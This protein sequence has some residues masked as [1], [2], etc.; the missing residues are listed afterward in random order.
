M[1][2]KG[3]EAFLK[4]HAGALLNSFSEVYFINSR[5]VGLAFLLLTLAN[6]RLALAGLITLAA[7]YGFA[8]LVGLREEFLQSGY[9]TYNPLLVGL[10]LGS[11]YG[12]S[13]LSLLLL[14]L[15]GVMTLVVTLAMAR[16]FYWYLGLPI[17][18][19]PFV[20][21]ISAM[22]LASGHYSNLFVASFYP[23]PHLPELPLPLWALGYFRSLAAIL[24]LPHSLLGLGLAVILLLASPLLFG[25]SVAGYYTGSLVSAAMTGSWEGAFLNLNHFNYILIA[26]GI[27]GVFLV[28]SPRSFLIAM[29]AVA[30]SVV[31][32][33]A[34]MVFW[35]TYGLPVLT[36]PFNL[37][38][39]GFV[40]ILRLL[41]N[42]L[43]ARR[44]MSAPEAT[45]DYH[46]SVTSRFDDC[47]IALALPFAGSW[48][49]WQGFS[50]PW[51][52]QGPWARAYDFILTDGEGQS[53]RGE[54]A[55]TKDYLAWGKPVLSPLSGRVVRVVKHHADQKI[56]Q[57]D[58]QNSWGNLVIIQTEDGWHV[59]LSHFQKDSLRVAE[60][61]WVERGS[62]LGLCGNSGNSP[63]PHIH[64]QVQIGSRIGESTL[65][66]RFS[67][68]LG[69]AGY[70]TKGLPEPGTWAESLP[71]APP[72]VASFPLTEKLVF[73]AIHGKGERGLVTWEVK[74]D[75][76]GTYYFDSGK[77]QLYFGRIGDCHCHYTLVGSDLSL[78]TL[79]LALPRWPLT[80]RRELEF[81]ESLPLGLLYG[82]I[83]RRVLLPL[84]AFYH[85]LGRPFGRYR[86]KNG[87]IRGTVSSGWGKK[88]VDTWAQIDLQKG[89]RG[90]SA[91]EWTYMRV[92]D[93]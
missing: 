43:V 79:F 89:L 59:E 37:V 66:F 34:V 5:L 24:F 12:V 20:A 60:G 85:Q 32:V 82:P 40:Y 51:T 74:M 23:A 65:D 13:W 52:H 93:E 31:L 28:A 41:G 48:T 25:L 70:V 53:F 9:Y 76:E 73:K 77:G 63:Q 21:V 7:A 57:I 54:G 84:G 75:A 86:L 42:P 29:L 90:F 33:D 58:Q 67:G 30:S 15:A 50:G 39:L 68:Y 35:A 11:V 45:L 17:L 88:Q 27:G 18:S 83:M 69:A 80:E 2:A 87:E 72:G 26:M 47:P 36:L 56:G 64:V 10:G 55:E 49:V 81:S 78:K 44:V 22:T 4:E 46:L 16:V 38:T 62:L 71:P 8:R 1:S 3:P 91:M 92:E 19:L 14:L 61:D 6:P